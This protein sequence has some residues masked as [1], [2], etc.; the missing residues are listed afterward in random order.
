MPTVQKCFISLIL[1]DKVGKKTA[2]LLCTANQTGT[3]TG[4]KL[5]FYAKHPARSKLAPIN[6][7][8]GSDTAEVWH[9][10]FLGVSYHLYHHIRSGKRHPCYIV[11]P[12]KLEQ[13]I[14]S[15]FSPNIQL[16][17][18]PL[19]STTKMAVARMRCDGDSSEV[20]HI[21]DTIILGQEKDSFAPLYRQPSH[22]RP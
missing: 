3:G 17:P 22:N 11:P 5:H 8:N 14:S 7:K 15:I 4:H 2:L 20:F 10:Q 18:I 6:N 21:I 12:T 16:G 9:R 19:Q 1:P 13:A